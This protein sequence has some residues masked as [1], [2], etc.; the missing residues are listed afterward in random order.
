MTNYQDVGKTRSLLV[1]TL[2][3]SGLVKTRPLYIFYPNFFQLRI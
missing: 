1:L 2:K 3:K